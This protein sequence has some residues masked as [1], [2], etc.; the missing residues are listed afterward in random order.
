MG[1]HGAEVVEIKRGPEVQQREQPA[2]TDDLL[3]GCVIGL[4]HPGGPEGNPGLPNQVHVDVDRGMP[5]HGQ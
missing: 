2:A 4:G 5:T 1:P 3:E